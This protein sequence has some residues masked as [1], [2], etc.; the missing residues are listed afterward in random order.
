MEPQIK[1]D[2]VAC[3]QDRMEFIKEVKVFKEHLN[4]SDWRRYGEFGFTGW[5][6]N[7][8]D[9]ENNDWRRYGE[10]GFTDWADNLADKENNDW[11]RYGEFGFG[12]TI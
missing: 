1:S 8:A 10:F 7:L 11:R 9:K 2:S 3:V 5:A 12:S 6:D 4:T